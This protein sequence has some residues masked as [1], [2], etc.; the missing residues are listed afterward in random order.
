MLTVAVSTPT[1]VKPLPS[2][3]NE[4]AVITPTAL[5]PPAVILTSS[6]NVDIPCTDNP[7]AETLGPCVPI[8]VRLL[9]SPRY[10][11]AVTTPVIF[12]PPL[13]VISVKTDDASVLIPG[14]FANPEPSPINFAAVII[15]TD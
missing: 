4:V 8:P 9:P 6:W 10:E 7:N 13:T 1:L 12:A 2:P 3:E 11:P 15:P 5:I 14:R